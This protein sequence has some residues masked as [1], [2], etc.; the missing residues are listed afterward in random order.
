MDTKELDWKFTFGKYKGKELAWV[1]LYKPSYVQWALENV[2]WF[3][4]SKTAKRDLDDSLA[5]KE[6]ASYDEEWEQCFRDAYGPWG[7]R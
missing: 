7:D 2:K 4:I 1:I 5:L 6:E 3:K